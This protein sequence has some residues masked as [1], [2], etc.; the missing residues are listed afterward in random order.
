[1]KAL[2][3]C[4]PQPSYVATLPWEIQGLYSAI[5]TCLLD[6]LAA[7]AEYPDS[8]KT[9]QFCRVGSGAVNRACRACVYIGFL[10]T[11]GL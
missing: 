7:A 6:V 9:K 3:I 1:M 11:E 4:P 8:P 10:A 5:A 2:Q